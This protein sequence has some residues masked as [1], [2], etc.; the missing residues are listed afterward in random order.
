MHLYHFGM[1]VKILWLLAVGLSCIHNN[2]QM[3]ISASHCGIGVH[4]QMLPQFSQVISSTLAVFT[5]ALDVLGWLN[6]III[7]IDAR[8]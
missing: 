1:S 8:F 7:V 2:S 3:A 5:F 4:S 6:I